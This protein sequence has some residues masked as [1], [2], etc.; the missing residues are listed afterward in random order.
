[1][2]FQGK[3]QEL[4]DQGMIDHSNISHDHFEINGSTKRMVKKMKKR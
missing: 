4:C 3:F 2:E 1:M